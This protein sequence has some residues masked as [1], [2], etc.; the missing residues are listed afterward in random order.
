MI[1]SF[2]RTP[3]QAWKWAMSQFADYPAGVK[4]PWQA[5]TTEDNQATR[6]VCNLCL[7]IERPLEG[8]P[9]AGSGWNM[10]GLKQYAEQL[11]SGENP[12]GFKYTYGERLVTYPDTEGNYTIDQIDNCI[13]RL[14]RH[15]ESRRA[16]AITWV[17][18][19]D[20]FDDE[21]P[22]IQS[23]DFLIRDG[24]LNATVFIRSWDLQRAA[25]CNMFG[26]AKLMEYV[27]GE[28][29]VPVGSLSIVAVSAHVYQ[30]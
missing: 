2:H 27:A 3:A 14:K 7:S 18:D 5:V 19:W 25:P 10:E 9:I 16:I 29:G 22:C 6:E 20:C 8:F 11:L 12:S 28:I 17:P 26:L 1:S 21:V 24:K 15:P 30:D 23:A 4:P 13:T